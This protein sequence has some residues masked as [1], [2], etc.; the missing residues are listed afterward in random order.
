MMSKCRR[1]QN[2]RE[3]VVTPEED[4]VADKNQILAELH[5]KT[6]FKNG[7]CPPKTNQRKEVGKS[8]K[9]RAHRTKLSKISQVASSNSNP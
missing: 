2:H 5:I 7:I 6:K 8:T 9:G 3:V 4:E 1:H